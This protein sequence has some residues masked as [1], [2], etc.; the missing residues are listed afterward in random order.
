MWLD[1]V[2]FVD[3]VIFGLVVSRVGVSV[4][5]VFIYTLNVF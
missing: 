4:M 5:D 1:E 3:L 2:D